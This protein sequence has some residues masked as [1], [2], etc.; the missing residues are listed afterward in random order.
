MAAVLAAW[1]VVKAGSMKSF[2]VV[3][4][5]GL[6]GLA[7]CAGPGQGHP[8]MAVQQEPLPPPAERHDF[9]DANRAGVVTFLSSDA[10]WQAWLYAIVASSAVDDAL[11]DSSTLDLPAGRL[12]SGLIFA[13]DGYRRAT[14]FYLTPVMVASSCLNLPSETAGAA[15][16]PNGLI[17]RYS[18]LSS[19]RHVFPNGASCLRST[20][21]VSEIDSA[22]G[23]AIV[24][25]QPPAA[26]DWQG[27][28]ARAL[29]WN[30]PFAQISQSGSY[31][32]SDLI[33]LVGQ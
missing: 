25:A 22:R 33:A 21:Y 13:W 4:A 18:Y 11:V 7:S 24:T 3:V 8:L 30:H 12:S 20:G 16:L 27:N 17:V 5:A 10:G 28:F 29:I 14:S 26:I 15:R 23:L 1:Q 6:M 9:T 19:A 32:V 31:S 2:R